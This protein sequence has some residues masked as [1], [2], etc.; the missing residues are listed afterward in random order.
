M[1]NI[2]EIVG[3]D[4]STVSRITCNKYADTP[5][6]MILLKG[7]FYRRPRNKEGDVISNKV[8]RT[9]VEEVVQKEDKKKPYTDQQ[10]ADILVRQRVYR[11]T[12]NHRQV[13]G[14]AEYTGGT[15]EGTFL[16]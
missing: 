14:P 3:L 8:I 15:D 13:P 16:I 7:S 5:F 1:K 6:G 10:L 9:M 11:G 2:A 4:I 12:K